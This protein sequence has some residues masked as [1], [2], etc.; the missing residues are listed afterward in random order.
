M[1]VNRQVA[2]RAYRVSLARGVRLAV[3]SERVPVMGA[4]PSWARRRMYLPKGAVAPHEADLH[5]QRLSLSRTAR[6]GKSCSPFTAVRAHAP[7]TP[8]AKASRGPQN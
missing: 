6:H 7:R 2:M 5:C 4:S 1:K 8:S 3:A